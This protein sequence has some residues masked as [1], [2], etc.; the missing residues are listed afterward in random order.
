MYTIWTDGAT[1]G[2]VLNS[3]TPLPPGVTIIGHG[4]PGFDYISPARHFSDQLKCLIGETV[5][6]ARQALRESFGV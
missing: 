3:K 2:Y 1:V 4:T 5:I 6:K